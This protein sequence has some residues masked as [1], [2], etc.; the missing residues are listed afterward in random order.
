MIAATMSWLWAGLLCGSPVALAGPADGSVVIA[1]G[2]ADEDEA[3]DEDGDWKKEGDT[4]EGGDKWV[5]VDEQAPAPVPRKP[6]PMRTIGLGT[7]GVGALLI[8]RGLMLRSELKDDVQDLS[9]EYSE[10]PDEWPD[11]ITSLQSQT[12]TMLWSGLAIG[13]LGGGMV[14]MNPPAAQPTSMG[15]QVGWSGRW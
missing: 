1:D 3:G 12:N 11:E 9:D 2:D 6:L 10:P 4:E 8:V 14:V 13:A 7:A 15:L 5:K